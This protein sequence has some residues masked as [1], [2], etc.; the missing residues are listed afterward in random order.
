MSTHQCDAVNFDGTA[1]TR[2]I[3]P[4]AELMC[5]Q[6]RVPVETWRKPLGERLAAFVDTSDPDACWIWRGQVDVSG[7]AK[8]QWGRQTLS[9]HRVTYQEVVGHIPDG[10]QLDHLCRTPACVNPAHLEPVTPRENAL[11]S[12]SCGTHKTHCDHGHEY[13]P[14]NTYRRGNKRFCRACSARRSAEYQARKRGRL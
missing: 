6:H 1:C 14:E 12:P 4:P 9:A 2:R 5:W 10:L 8:I 7:Y 3:V 13:T 11:R